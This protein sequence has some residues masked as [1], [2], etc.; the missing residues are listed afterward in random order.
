MVN[1]MVAYVTVRHVTITR[2]P[3]AQ[4]LENS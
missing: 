2:D 3:K 4:Y 1:R